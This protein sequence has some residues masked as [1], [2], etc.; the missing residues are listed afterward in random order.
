MSSTK[1]ARDIT[2]GPVSAEMAST[3]QSDSS[4]CP[5]G[6]RSLWVSVAGDIRVTLI[7][8]VDGE[9]VTYPSV[10]VGRWVGQVKRLWSTGT[11]A[12][13]LFVEQ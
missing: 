10:P 5:A 9:H 1:Q 6:V 13:V 11:T 2:M 4:D 7:D 12:T 8:M 3:Y